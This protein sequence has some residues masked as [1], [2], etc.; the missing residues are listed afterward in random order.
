[1]K[2]VKRKLYIWVINTPGKAARVTQV[3]SKTESPDAWGHIL[4]YLACRGRGAALCY[5][6]DR[7]Q[8]RVC[9]ASHSV[10]APW[11]FMRQ[12]WLT[13]KT[14]WWDRLR[15]R[16]ARHDARREECEKKRLKKEW[17]RCIVKTR[18][19]IACGRGDAVWRDM[20]DIKDE[21]RSQGNMT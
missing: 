18:G 7:K 8:K 19:D 2:V 12:S 15:R 20:R 11:C 9:R 6:R 5:V 10:V 13:R 4:T 17:R 14:V 16:P 3:V 1:M 21:N